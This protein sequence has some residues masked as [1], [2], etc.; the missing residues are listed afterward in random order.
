MKQHPSPFLNPDPADE[1]LRNELCYARWDLYPVTEG[2]LLVVPYRQFASY[3]DA[4]DSERGA[5][6]ALVDEAKR[7]LD[8]RYRPDGYNIGINVG[9]PAGQTI[10]HV[11]VHVIPRRAGDVLE[12]RGGVRGVI[13]AR[14]L[15]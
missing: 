10:M 13:P 4:T 15:Y 6:W 9:A 5:L 11:H 8:A 12:P 7:Y 14:Q 2:H 3:F 1:V